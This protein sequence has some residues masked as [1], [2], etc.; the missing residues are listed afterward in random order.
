MSKYVEIQSL[1][2]LEENFDR[3]YDEYSHVELVRLQD[4]VAEFFCVA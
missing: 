2:E 3:L 1:S 4:N